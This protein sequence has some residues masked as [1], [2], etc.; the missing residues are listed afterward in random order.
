ME[1]IGTGG[2]SRVYRALQAD[3]DRVVAVK[4]INSGHDPDVARRFDRERKAMGRLSNHEGIVPV[5]SSGVT[6]HGDPFLVMPYYPNGSLQAQIDMGPLDWQAAVGYIDVAAETVAAAHEAGVVHLDIKPANILLTNS[7]APRVADF[8]IA[9]LTS[10]PAASARTTGTAFTPAYSAPETFLDGKASPAADVYGLGASLWALLVGHP[11]FLGPGDDAN[12]MAVIGRV[13]NNPLG[14]VRHLAPEPICRVISKAM[15]KNPVDRFHNARDF[16]VALKAAMAQSG[17]N[18]TASY[19][20]AA[21][22]GVSA[23]PTRTDTT[24]FHEFPPP[25]PYG[26]RPGPAPGDR[27]QIF[28]H[29]GPLSPAPNV[30]SARTI[31]R[32]ADSVAADTGPNDRR[33]LQ[34]TADPSHYA[35]GPPPIVE[36]T[37]LIDFDKFRFGPLLVGLVSLLG[38]LL[39]TAWALTRGE[40]GQP[41]SGVSALNES[42]PAGPEID[43]ATTASTIDLSSTTTT[44]ALSTTASTLPTTVATGG[45]TT[46]ATTASTTGAT[47]SSSSTTET[48]ISTTSSSISSSTTSSSVPG[49]IQPPDNVAAR[50][51]R[52]EVELSWS[53]P[54][55]GPTP[56]SYIVYRDGV[57][58]DEATSSP[59]IDTTVTP[60]SYR[61]RV[62]SL[63]PNAAE[64][65]LSLP[66]AVDVPEPVDL[67]DLAVSQVAPFSQR[68]IN[69]EI[70][71][72]PCMDTVRVSWREDGSSDTPEVQQL[73]PTGC[74]TTVSHTIS[75]LRPN[76]AYRINV[77]ATG[78]DGGVGSSTVVFST[79]NG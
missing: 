74:V 62:A 41:D 4:V 23:A 57:I 73:D 21:S 60:G 13:V 8:G 71:S 32:G 49:P 46:A 48:T 59:Y 15:A 36:R 69:L 12:L 2:S 43:E 64:S 27:T 16:S 5:Y 75:D 78:A 6:R 24:A 3:L 79:T 55:S 44:G 66:A 11:P 53:A 28:A 45:R 14:D 58:L 67:D 37:P 19:G 47:S 63:G 68:S 18:G 20:A 17:L 26:S 30:S 76:T 72:N 38:L 54:S 22:S 51:V 29:Q 7:G 65:D 39:L 77:T 52:G 35:G 42:A 34:P 31:D 40:A 10:S 1:Q 9:K 33:L 61:Y 50:A 70:T 56:T 25:V